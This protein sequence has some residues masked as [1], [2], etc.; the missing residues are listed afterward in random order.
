[1]DDNSIDIGGNVSGNLIYGDGN[2][3]IYAPRQLPIKDAGNFV[4]FSHNDL[5]TGR[6]SAL[7]HLV[8]LLTEQTNQAVL[9]IP[10]IAGM[11]G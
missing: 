3:I 2:Q 1:M 5:F 7:M 10:A 9:V 4:P 11:G 6:E 8:Q